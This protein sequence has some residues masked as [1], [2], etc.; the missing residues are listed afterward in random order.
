MG[1]PS[2]V[3]THPKLDAIENEIREGRTLTEI[4]GRYGL[5]VQSLSRWAISR[6]A[7]LA[8]EL[9]EDGISVSSLLARLT[10]VADAAREARRQAT[11]ATPAVRARALETESRVLAQILNQVG[12]D[13]T[14]VSAHLAAW[15]R[16][17]GIVA[18]HVSKYPD[19]A[20]ELIAA[21]RA[22]D[23]LAGLGDSLAARIEK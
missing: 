9:D 8:A 20:P 22:D 13:D 5:S 23:D 2:S 19:T 7:R 11:Y 21:L 4:A 14:T 17:A 10:D 16:F 15:Q 1:R 18:K 6:K 12:I 3:T